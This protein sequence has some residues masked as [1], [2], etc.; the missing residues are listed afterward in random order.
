[1]D[2]NGIPIAHGMEI[3]QDGAVVPD[4]IL[5]DPS[6]DHLGTWDSDLSGPREIPDLGP[7]KPVMPILREFTEAMRRHDDEEP[8]EWHNET[9]RGAGCGSH[10]HVSF[11]DGDACEDRR[12]EGYTIAWNTAVE[13]AP[14]LAPFWCFDWE[15][16]FRSSASRWAA[17]QL[18]RYG[19]S[20][21]GRK[22]EDPPTR[23]NSKSVVM[24]PPGAGGKPLTIELRINENHPAFALPGLTFLRRTMTKAMRGGWSPKIAGDRRSVLNDVYHS[25]Y[26]AGSGGGLVEAMKSAGPIEFEE[27]RGIPGSDKLEY[28]SAWDVLLKIMAVNGVDRG[29]YD[30]H[31][32]KLIQAAGDGT[33]VR[34]RSDEVVAAA[35]L[36]SARRMAADGGERVATGAELGPQNNTRAMWHTLDPDFRWDV[37]PE[38]EP[39]Y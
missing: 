12:V 25:L 10:A 30:D 32:K 2:L 23:D 39:R 37:G 38:V 20:T 29:A 3:E 4:E 36:D 21:M 15:N 9:R 17:P 18:T 1:M 26:R 14:F 31:V 19:Q 35:G 16:G 7:S 8:W 24:N 22:L 33:E 5:E 13:L 34:M 27:G 6:G 11:A 28:D